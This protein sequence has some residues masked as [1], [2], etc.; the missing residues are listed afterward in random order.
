MGK[1]VKVLVETKKG[2]DYLGRSEHNK[3][4]QFQSKMDLIG[5]I[6]PVKITDSR[7][8]ILIGED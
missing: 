7:K 8:W 6:V 2:K 5:E 3:T 4:V 1:T